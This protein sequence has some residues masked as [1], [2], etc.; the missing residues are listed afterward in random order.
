MSLTAEAVAQFLRSNPAFLDAHPDVLDALTVPPAHGGSAI[1]L[2]ERQLASLRD[3]NRALE[4]KLHELVRFGQE[5]DATIERMHRFA[6]AAMAARDLD[7]LLATLYFHLREDFAVP[8]VALRLWADGGWD[9]PEFGATSAE[10]RIFAESLGDPYCGTQPMFETASW[11]GPAEPIPASFGYLPL[12]T[13]TTF[14]LLAL[15]SDAADRFTPETGTL[16]LRRIGELVSVALAR[17]VTPV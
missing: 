8:H 11:F 14:G 16:Y 13:E 7:A 2:G 9:R 15:A 3:K 5:N 10:A 4:D 1:P 17:F 12:R 6:L